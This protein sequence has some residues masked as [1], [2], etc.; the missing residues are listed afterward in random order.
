MRHFASAFFFS[1]LVLVPAVAASSPLTVVPLTNESQ[2]VLVPETLG[3]IVNANDPQSVE[4]GRQ[5]ARIRGVPTSNLIQLRLPKVNYIAKRLMVRE[6]ERLRAAA[7]YDKLL[8]FALAFDKP[9][10]V[11]ANQSIT[12]AISQGIATMTWKGSLQCDSRKS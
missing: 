4:L 9:Y 7:T 8:A 3:V 1:C 5:Y 12:S 6:L 10:K 11:D 2:P